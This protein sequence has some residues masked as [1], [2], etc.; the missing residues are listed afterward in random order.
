MSKLKKL[1][2]NLDENKAKI[3]MPLIENTAFMVV[4]LAELQEIINKKGYVEEY[5]N[6]ENQIGIKKLAEL[7]I[8]IQLSKNLTANIKLM[9]ENVPPAER[10]ELSKLAQ[11]RLK[12]D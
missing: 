2:K 1:F 7:D 10:K 4:S 9:C 6:G 3:I 5:Q 12:Y 8:Y 11:L